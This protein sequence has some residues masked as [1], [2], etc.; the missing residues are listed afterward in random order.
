MCFYKF[1][2]LRLYEFCLYEKINQVVYAFK[3]SKNYLKVWKQK[4]SIM[5][6]GRNA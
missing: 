4:N 3:L 6:T 5:L 2:P 1:G